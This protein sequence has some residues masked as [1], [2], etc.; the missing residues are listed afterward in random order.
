EMI[1]SINEQLRSNLIDTDFKDKLMNAITSCY[2]ERND[3]KTAFALFMNTIMPDYGVLFIDPSDA[4]IKR[5]LLPIFEKELRTEPKLCEQ[6]ITASAEIEKNY[7]L[8][9]KPKVI[10]MFFLHNSNRLLIEPREGGKFALKNS[11]RRF[12]NEEIFQTLQENPELFSPNV[13]LRPICQDYLLPTA[14]YVGGPAEISYFAQL[15]P[16]YKHYEL[17][18]PVV[19]PRASITIIESKISKFMNN[20]NVNFEDIFQRNLLVS[21]V[22]EKL[23]EV[24]I[25]EEI[26][27]YSDELNKIFYD[28][29]NM[30]D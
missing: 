23:S 22:V 10:N 19:F 9:V 17:T 20:F 4:E 28:M 5:L 29:K 26:S 18:M 1:N 14:A 11:K 8:Q 7:D 21:K 24:K 6:I 25:E 13:V 12:E 30:T 16:A 15:K 27:K 2:N 3:Y